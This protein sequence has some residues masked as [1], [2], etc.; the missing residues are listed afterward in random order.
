MSATIEKYSR[1]QVLLHWATLL[2]LLVSFVSHEGMKTAWRALR[3]G[4]EGAEPGALAQVHVWVGVTILVLTL[5]RLVLR[6]TQGA[7]RPVEGQPPLMT[8]AAA[9][10]HGLLYL[11]L[12]AIPLTGLMAWF[13]G[14]TDLGEVHEVLFNLSLALVA[15][16]VA[17]ALYHQFVLKDRLMARMR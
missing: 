9:I 12:L 14:I 5:L 13:G 6:F 2:L 1:A 4:T 7:P 15:G 3:R 10:L 16:H 11:M 17:A 8:V